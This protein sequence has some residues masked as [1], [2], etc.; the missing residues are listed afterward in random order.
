MSKQFYCIRGRGIGRNVVK[1]ETIQKKKPY[2]DEDKKSA[3]N[4]N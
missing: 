4:K 1:E 3:I 2:Q